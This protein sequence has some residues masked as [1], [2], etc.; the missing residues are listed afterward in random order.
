MGFRKEDSAESYPRD[1]M[2]VLWKLLFDFHKEVLPN[3]IKL[4]NLAL[5]MPYQTADCERGFSAQN[6]IKTARRNRLGKVNLNI[7]MTIKCE[8]GSIEHYNFEKAVKIWKMKKD[9]RICNK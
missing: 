7:L 2:K 3:M 5:I 6:G 8:G 9:R 4:A 1:S